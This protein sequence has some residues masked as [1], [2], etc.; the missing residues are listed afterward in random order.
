MKRLKNIILTIFA[1]YVLGFFIVT[2]L[3]MLATSTQVKPIMQIVHGIEYKLYWSWVQHIDEANGVRLIWNQ[4]GK[5]WCQRFARC[6]V[7]TKPETHNNALKLRT[8]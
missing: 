1:F 8:Q 2:P 3:S 6:E 7:I 4:N 5:Y